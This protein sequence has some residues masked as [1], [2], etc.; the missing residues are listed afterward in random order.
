V[1]AGRRLGGVAFGALHLIVAATRI[2]PLRP[3]N[4]DFDLVG[5]GWLSAATFGAVSVFHGMAVVAMAN[6]YSHEIPAATATRAGQA[7]VVLPLALP[8]LLLVP[9]AVLL[10]PLAL[11]L[12][13]ALAVSRTGPAVRLARSRGTVLAGRIVFGA[14][15]VALLPGTLSDLHDV[16]VR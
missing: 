10:V 15:A 9:G 16:I 5:P 12:V 14:T 3:D 8:A 2:D 11:G 6:R 1:V 13:V 7:R 4:P